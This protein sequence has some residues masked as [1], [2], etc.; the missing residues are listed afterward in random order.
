MNQLIFDIEGDSLN[1]SLVWCLAAQ[2]PHGVKSTISYD[3]MRQKLSAADILIGHNI[4]R[5]DIPVLERILGIRITGKIVDTL[6]LSW[7]LYP[8]RK[9]HGLEAWGEEFGIKKPPIIVWDDPELIDEY[10]HRCEQDVEIN[11]LLWNKMWK[12][13]MLMYEDEGAVWRLIDYLSFKMDCA[14]EQERSGWKL[15]EE[16]CREAR[17]LLQIK[18]DEVVE[19]L[20]AAMPKVPEIK[21]KEKPKKP[22]KQ[23]GTPSAIGCVWN[24]LLKDNELPPD[25]DGIVEVVVGWDEPN[26]DSYVQIKKWLTECGWIPETFKYKRDKETGETKEIPQINLEHGAGI[27]PSVKKLYGKYPEFQYLEGYGVVTHRLSVL[28]GFLEAVDEDGYVRAR[29]A[30]LT[31]TLRFK[32][33]EV[34]NLP[35]VDKPYGKEIRGSLTVEEGWELCGSDMSSLEDR[36][37]C[38]YIFPF[39]PKYVEE[40]STPGYDPHMSLAVSDKAMTFEQM[41]AYKAGTDKSVAPIRRMYKSVNYAAQYGAG[42]PRIAITAGTPEKKGMALHK[43]YWKKNWAIKEVAKEQTIRTIRGQMWLLNPINGFYYSLRDEKDIFSTLVQGSASYVFDLWVQTFRQKRNQLTGQFHDEVVLCI[44]E[45][46]R[47]QCEDLLRSSIAAVNDNLKLNR[48]LDI[49][50]QFGSDYSQIH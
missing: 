33:K 9:V 45:G 38:H 12:H 28:N 40:I 31:N 48:D 50:V 4:Q 34:V 29:I 13:L 7:Y 24:K 19:Q 41:E 32:H 39:D 15:D 44:R 30:G 47:D 46:Y 5:F 27:C 25:Y 17:D 3:K 11:I 6:A 2:T 18:K 35:G 14:R 43:A 20:M 36:L 26:P 10:R 37:K 23:D 49:D 21:K 42:G 22:F 16:K 1:P 8:N